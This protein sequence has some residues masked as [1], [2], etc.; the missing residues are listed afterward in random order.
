VTKTLAVAFQ[1]VA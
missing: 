1:T